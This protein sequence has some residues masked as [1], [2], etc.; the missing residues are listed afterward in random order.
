[1]P[2]RQHR[3]CLLISPMVFRSYQIKTF[4]MPL[5]LDRVAVETERHAA[6]RVILLSLHDAVD[7]IA[8][9]ARKQR[10]ETRRQAS[11]ALAQAHRAALQKTIRLFLPAEL[12]GGGEGGERR[13]PVDVRAGHTVE[14]AEVIVR[15]WVAKNAGEGGGEEGARVTIPVGGFLAGY[16][17]KAKALARRNNAANSGGNMLGVQSTLLEVQ[18]CSGVASDEILLEPVAD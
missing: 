13:G 2:F 10:I 14:E 3:V 9:T 12:V 17:R 5:V 16:L 6:V 15:E 18:Q 8:E 4:F 7:G 11:E 1:M